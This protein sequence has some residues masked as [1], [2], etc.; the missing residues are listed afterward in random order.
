MVLFS[1]EELLLVLSHSKTQ[2]LVIYDTTF[3]VHQQHLPQ[4]CENNHWWNMRKQS[5]MKHLLICGLLWENFYCFFRSGGGTT[6]RIVSGRQNMSK[7]YFAQIP[8]SVTR[9]TKKVVLPIRLLSEWYYVFYILIITIEGRGDFE[10]YMGDIGIFQ[11]FLISV[12]VVRMIWK[13]LCWSKESFQVGRIPH[14]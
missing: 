14:V 11:T 6:P 10:F 7:C 13:I 2:K 9:G 3:Y 4:I 1:F 12:I 5:V 8:K